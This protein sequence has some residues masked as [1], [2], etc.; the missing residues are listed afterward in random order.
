MANILNY[1]E[2]A[3]LNSSAAPDGWPERSM[4]FSEVNDTGREMMAAFARWYHDSQ[5]VLNE[6]EDPD[7][8]AD[9]SVIETGTHG[10]SPRS[11]LRIRPLVAP[12]PI[13]V[14]LTFGVKMRYGTETATA[15]FRPILANPPTDTFYKSVYLVDADGNET[16]YGASSILMSRISTALDLPFDGLIPQGAM[17]TGQVYFITW[18]GRRWY[19]R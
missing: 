12:D 14:G 11:R 18:N 6:L 7:N 4:Q 8:P 19:L 3:V 15:T 13:P 2:D 1:S 17:V 5:G 9:S 16:M 10:A